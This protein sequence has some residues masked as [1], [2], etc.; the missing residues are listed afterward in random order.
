[1][2]TCEWV[3]VYV[4]GQNWPLD[5]M[6]LRRA[7]EGIVFFNSAG[8]LFV[9]AESRVRIEPQGKPWP[10]ERLQGDRSEMAEAVSFTG[11]LDVTLQPVQP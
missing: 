6:F 11:L 2:K 1:V 5:V 7:K 3:K 10:W 8:E 4:E 9:I